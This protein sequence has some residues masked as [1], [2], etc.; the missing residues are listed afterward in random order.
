M[1][2]ITDVTARPTETLA[3]MSPEVYRAAYKRGMSLSAYLEV[4]DPSE[5]Y[6]DGLDAFQRLLKVANIRTVSIPEMGVWAD[7]FD[8]FGQSDQTRAL[9][10]EFFARAWRRAATGREVMTRAL[11]SSSDNVSG[12][13]MFPIAY[14]AA[15]RE[16]QIAPAIPLAELIAVTTPI[17]GGVYEAYYLTD[18][19]AQERK[20][21][22]GEGAT[23]PTAYLTGGDHAIKL[24]KYG[25]SL[26]VS[27]EVLRRQRIDRIALHIA[28][29]AVQAEA[30]KVAAVITTIVSGDGNTSTS[31]TNYNL[32]VLDT[33]ATAG[34][35]TLK[36]WLNFKM[37]FANPYVC[38]HVLC[39]AADALSL[40]LLNAGSANIPLVAIQNAAGL[41]GFQHI[42]PGL[43]DNTRLG[44][45]SDAPANYIVGIDA[46]FAIERV[47]EMGADI[48]EIERY[49]SRQT[50]AL[51]M[52]E[53][54][55][56]D[57]F[58]QNACKTLHISV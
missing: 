2:Q 55:G 6:N 25:R 32:T 5:G 13:A 19:T 10:P 57:V 21:R 8:A 49:A 3:Q 52:T 56:Y 46:R 45:T 7:E 43:A 31:A 33:G 16:K 23:V 54:E 17:S 22:V 50:Q 11:Y 24:L 9:V 35:L 34:T 15:A 20:V 53:V 18:V 27:Y 37:Q 36:G 4:Q 30:D 51:I 28:R 29:L 1:P 40:M 47:Y 12:T 48:S 41:G 14:A 38:T 39:Q 58:D 42:N 26:E 44:W